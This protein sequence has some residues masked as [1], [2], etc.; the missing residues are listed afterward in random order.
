[1][2]GTIFVLFGPSGVGKTTLA[3]L[4]LQDKALGL[5]SV[6]SYT[7]RAPRPGEREG[8][9]YYFISQE[10]FEQK[11]KADYFLE[12]SN[13]Y[14]AYYGCSKIRVEKLLTAGAD[15]L[16][17]LDRDGVKAVK[18]YFPRAI[19]IEIVPVSLE[20]LEQRIQQ[21]APLSAQELAFRTQKAAQE[22]QEE[23]K[24]PLADEIIVNDDL[25]DAFKKLKSVF[26][27]KKREKSDR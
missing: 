8:I 19:A 14:G 12:W 3:R 6:C 26:L 2:A 13:A 1:M 20:I 4:L 9:D 23:Q 11:I 24:K 21:R 18:R 16:L 25:E 7:T 27:A 22:L 5:V 17:V 15:V 10:D